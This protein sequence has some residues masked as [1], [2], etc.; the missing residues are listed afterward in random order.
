MLDKTIT[1]IPN[2]PGLGVLCNCLG[3]IPIGQQPILNFKIPIQWDTFSEFD[4]EQL[5]SMAQAQGLAPLMYWVLSKSGKFSSIPE[6]ARNSLRLNYS[7]TWIKNQI[8]FKEL[9]SLARTFKQA[10]IPLVLLKGACFVLTIYPDIGL[11]PMGDLDVLVP[12][13][14]ITE[15]V[16]IAR[17]L[18][19]GIPNATI[20]EAFPGLNNLLNHET[21][22]QK[23]GSSSTLL[24]IHHSLMANNAFLYA[25]PMDWFW[26]QTEPLGGKL[27][28]DFQS[29]RML[30][31]TAQVLYGSAH[32]MLEHGGKD[33]PLRWFYDLDRL[34][35][36]YPEDM[37]WDLLVSQAKFFEWGSAL[38]AALSKTVVCFN[39]PIPEQVLSSLDGISDRNKKLVTQKQVQPPATH[40]LEEYQNLLSLKGSIRFRV[41]LA[42]V[43]PSPAYMRW[44]YRFNSSWRLPKFY[45]L[46][47]TGIFLDLM[48][49]ILHLFLRLSPAS[50]PT[51]TSDTSIV[52]KK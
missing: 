29:L 6:S 20:P 7:V 23:D 26:E 35:R 51:K 44:R 34:I 39:T 12:T 31:P 16:Q 40:L 33:A 37:D 42:L 19:F 24:E 4:W 47:W 45:L 28:S 48:R 36:S 14:R 27:A 21:C 17:S 9:E 5:V 50:H 30:T 3:Q 41:L 8:I 1:T 22:L 25:V 13:S 15:A 32:A 38:D 49:T 2:D 11:R 18:G 52:N 10:D 43:F 46:R